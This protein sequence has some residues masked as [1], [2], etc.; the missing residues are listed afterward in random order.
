VGV[1]RNLG[2]KA[3]AVAGTVPSVTLDIGPHVLDAETPIS[4]QLCLRGGS[5][6]DG[7]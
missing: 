3:S 4:A 6:R 1:V 2:Q 7:G 5:S